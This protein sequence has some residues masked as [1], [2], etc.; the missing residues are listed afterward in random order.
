M[1]SRLGNIVGYTEAG[2][3]TADVFRVFLVF[4]IMAVEAQI[5]PI[6]SVWWVIVVVMVFVVHS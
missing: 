1:G 3:L 6:T 4:P 5:L 2:C